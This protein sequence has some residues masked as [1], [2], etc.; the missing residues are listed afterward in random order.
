[1]SDI[2]PREEIQISESP[3]AQVLAQME[4]ARQHLAEARTIAEVKRVADGMAAVCEWLRRQEGVGLAVTNEGNLL[5]LQAQRRI[6]D[7]IQQPGAVAERGRPEKTSIKGGFSPPTL[8]SLGFTWQEAD[9]YREMT[10]IGPEVISELAQ[11]ATAKGKEITQADV[12]RAAQK[13]KDAEA[14]A[15]APKVNPDDRPPCPETLPMEFRNAVVCGD[16]RELAAQLPDESIALCFCDPVYDRVGDYEWLARECERV[17][18]PGGSLIVQCGNLRR[19][20]CEVAM[21]RTSLQ[22]V[23]LL[24]E[25]YPYA[26]GRLF[27]SKVFIGWKPYLWFSSGPRKTGWVMNRFKVGGKTYADESKDIHPWGDSEQFSAG[28]LGKLCGPGDV[29]WDPFTGSGTVPVVAARLGVPFVAFEIDPEK[30]AMAADRVAG[31]PRDP[32]LQ[33]EMELFGET[34]RQVA[35]RILVQFTQGQVDDLINHLYPN[36]Q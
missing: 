7:L 34:T 35:D 14:K 22:F 26:I 23:D 32:E 31:T 10:V 19:F 5:R 16:A 20:E 36:E 15:A 1:M 29:V 18:S 9:R 21:R 33:M 13:V 11:E 17:L 28:L 12:L 2:V 3:E 6:G 4:A 25:V 24:V 30:A 27:K 8:R